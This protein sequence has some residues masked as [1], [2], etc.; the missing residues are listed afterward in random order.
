MDAWSL[1][2]R[3]GAR[4]FETA[5][6]ADI[7]LGGLIDSVGEPE[8]SS[9]LIS[10]LNELACVDFF[11][12]Y[13]LDTRCRPQMFL[14][15]SKAGADVSQDCF[16]S[17]QAR[18]H[19]QDHTFDA[20]KQIAGVENLAMTYAHQ[21]HFSGPHR[22]AIYD[23][24]GIQDRLSVVCRTPHDS[25]LATNLYRFQSNPTFNESDVDAIA[26]LAGSLVSCIRK[27]VELQARP[28]I[29]LGA[30]GQAGATAQLSRLCPR[31]TARE[32]DV[33][34]GLLL[35]RTYDGIAVDLGLSVA[36]VKTYRL[37]AFD[38]LGINFRN[39]L[40]AI[41]SGLADAPAG[42]IPPRNRS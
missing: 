39:Q 42:G 18:L 38:K 19:A 26:S 31:L 21:T 29:L 11:S 8:F 3:S 30:S 37:R 2:G 41:V 1:T 36:T 24:H 22:R 7:V 15:F 13:E 28:Q 9:R 25:F 5:R 27:H 20:A 23:R 12:V 4:P 6:E 35:G 34:A 14:S 16:R 32:L 33:C 40:F 17:Y 10:G